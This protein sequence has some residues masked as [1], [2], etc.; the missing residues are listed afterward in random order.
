MQLKKEHKSVRGALALATCSLLGAAPGGVN[1]A[2]SDWEVD[3]ALLLYSEGGDRLNIIEPVVN[4]SKPL[5]DD[6]SLSL[7]LVLD[8]LTGSSPNGAIATDQ[9]QTFTNPSGNGSYT[10][11]PG[12]TPLDPT[13]KDTR[14]AL[15]ASW[16]MPLSERLSGVFGA[17]FSNEY[18]YQSIGASA[19]LKRDF[20]NRNT[21]VSAGLSLSQDTVDP[22]GGA[23]YGLSVVPDYPAV[24]ET[25]GGSQDKSVTD[26]LLGLTQVINRSTLMQL[27]YTY[28]IDDG[29]LSDPYK[30]LSVTD[31]NGDVTGYRFEERPDERARHALYWRTLH[32]F[33]EDV[34]DF[35]YRYYSDDWGIRSHTVDMRYR[36]E[37]G[38]GHYL[39]PHLRWYQQS[40][41]DF[42][43][44]KL[45]EGAIPEYA[46]ADYRLGN[47]TSNTLG[48][49]YGLA[50]SEEKEL[51]VRLEFMSQSDDDG[52]FEDVDAIIV[53]GSYSFLF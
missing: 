9:V 38:G 14:V 2:D 42:Y 45:D 24:K 31:I 44:Y 41:A 27:N 40:A 39:Q 11:A 29:Y 33:S 4:L 51:S 15:S 50:F 18:D 36:Y 43:H 16:E 26:L 6:E 53:Q 34:I 5:G 19:T 20:N 1:A 48:V 25:Q 47:M 49:K 3:T 21:T 46:S 37:L 22:V 13:F 7:R 23:P 17:N 52:R 35:S 30:L 32:H 12:E 28:G 10:V 8:T